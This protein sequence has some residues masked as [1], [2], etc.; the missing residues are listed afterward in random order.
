[1]S[2][3]RRS[4][5]SSSSPSV[6][7]NAPWKTATSS[8]ITKTA[9]SRRISS[10]IASRS[11]SR[12]RMDGHLLTTAPRVSPSSS[13]WMN[14]SRSSSASAASR[15]SRR[16]GPPR[17][18]VRRSGLAAVG[19]AGL[20]E[21]LRPRPRAPRPR[22]R[23][24]TAAARARRPRTSRAPGRRPR[25]GGR[26]ACRAAARARRRRTRPPRATRSS[27]RSRIS[28]RASS[29]STPSSSSR[30]AK[31]SIGS[32]LRHS[33]DLL[34][35]P[36]DLGVGGRVAAEAVGERLDHRR[37]ALLAGDPDVLG[38]RLAHRQHV[39]AVGA[40]AGHA[41][42]LGLLRE[43][44]D[45]RVALDRRAHP[46]EVVLEDEDDR[47]PPER[48]QVHRLAEVAGVRGAVAE[49]ADGDVVGALVVARRARARRPAAGCR[50][51][52]RSRP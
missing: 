45:R 17:A 47:Q 32:F 43:V 23:R 34:L 14:S 46:V 7:L 36:V 15:S 49:H 10:A 12:I 2:R 41:E 13:S 29:A 48:R 8:P 24:R 18:P 20:G 37:A 52:S 50:R 9:S 1:M 6:T 35:G 19:G 4:P 39:H 42:A 38:D 16:V 27:I 30:S 26:R 51:R 5:N 25:R 11:A 33:L 40:H 21:P 22:A 31:T 28:S 44:G 3:T